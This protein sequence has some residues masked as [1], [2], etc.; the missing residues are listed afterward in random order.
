M[1]RQDMRVRMRVAAGEEERGVQIAGK[2]SNEK[3]GTM[4]QERERKRMRKT[5]AE[6]TGENGI[7]TMCTRHWDP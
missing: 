6:I 1:K 3:E 2:R 7:M 4:G 5:E